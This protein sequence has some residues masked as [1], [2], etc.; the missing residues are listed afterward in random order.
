MCARRCRCARRFSVALKLVLRAEAARC[1]LPPGSRRQLDKIHEET[2]K[3]SDSREAAAAQESSAGE[4]WIRRQ[5]RRQVSSSMLRLALGRDTSQNAC[6][7]A[8]ARGSM[9]DR[10]SCRARRSV[11]DAMSAAELHGDKERPQ[12]NRRTLRHSHNHLDRVG[13]GQAG[14]PGGRETVAADGETLFL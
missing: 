3:G 10:T 6:K 5:M 14:G 7:L 12:T 4:G 2:S 9:A 1:T 13:L 8:T 11:H